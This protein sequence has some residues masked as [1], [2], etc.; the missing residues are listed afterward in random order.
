[1]P[2]LTRFPQKSTLGQNTNKLLLSLSPMLTG[3]PCG[4]SLMV[5]WCSS[6]CQFCALFMSV[7]C[8]VSVRCQSVCLLGSLVSR[9]VDVQ[10]TLVVLWLFSVIVSWLFGVDWS[11]GLSAGCSRLRFGCP[12]SVS[13]LVSVVSPLV[14][15]QG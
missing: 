14:R 1:M 5:L 11:T 4:P 10:C 13:G 3:N 15:G 9:L 2:H 6:W 12:V 8:L 7:V